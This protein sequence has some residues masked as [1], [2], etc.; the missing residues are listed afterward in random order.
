MSSLQKWV[1][2]LLIVFIG[3]GIGCGIWFGFFSGVHAVEHTVAQEQRAAV[4]TGAAERPKAKIEIEIVPRDCTHV[5]H[6]DLD[7]QSLTMYVKNDCHHRLNYMEYH[8]ESLSP[9]GVAIHGGYQ[10]TAFC[11]I[12]IEPA[13]TAECQMAVSDD[14]RTAHMR[15]WSEAKSW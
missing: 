8:W 4:V 14:D 11:A 15:V 12:P 1:V 10:N 2:V 3:T 5:T 7:G 6:V 9:S 13:E